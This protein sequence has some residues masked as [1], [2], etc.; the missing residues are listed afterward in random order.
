MES[1]HNDIL[2]QLNNNPNLEQIH[3]IT[4]KYP[5]FNDMANLIVTHG[6]RTNQINLIK[7]AMKNGATEDI[8]NSAVKTNP[9][10]ANHQQLLTA[11]NVVTNYLYPVDEHVDMMN[12]H[13]GQNF[14]LMFD[15][16]KLDKNTCE[17]YGKNLFDVYDESN[18][19]D[20]LS[21]ILLML[22]YHYS[23]PNLLFESAPFLKK[24]ITYLQYLCAIQD[25]ILNYLILLQQ[26]YYSVNINREIE[27][28]EILEWCF[29]NPDNPTEKTLIQFMNSQSEIQYETSE[30]G[31]IARF[32]IEQYC[33]ILDMTYNFETMLKQ[34]N[35]TYSI[36]LIKAMINNT[37]K[38]CNLEYIYALIVYDF[39][40]NNCFYHFAI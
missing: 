30:D 1:I 27:L 12:K 31:P 33:E 37:D 10:I 20:D 14:Q 8:I 40:I 4:K 39:M 5:D 7:Y 11:I 22:L 34:I 19:P 26:L 16:T 21:N 32:S 23:I 15:D 24:G 28:P 29:D 17:Q 36:D 2:S 25:N 3:E 9:L 13:I 35:D 18:Y 38:E 6:I